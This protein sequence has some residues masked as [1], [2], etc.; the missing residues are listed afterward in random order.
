M[1]LKVWAVGLAYLCMVLAYPLV[2][3][4][5]NK[6][7]YLKLLL[8]VV[9]FL[10]LMRLHWLLYF[11]IYMILLFEFSGEYLFTQPF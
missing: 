8:L 5:G 3:Q 4:D 1:N 9:L 7:K 2:I 6:K 11:K 10:M